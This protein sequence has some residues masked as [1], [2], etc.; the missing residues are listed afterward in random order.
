MTAKRLVRVGLWLAAAA[1]AAAPAAPARAAERP[2]GSTVNGL[3]L[4]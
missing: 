4:W 1:C 3:G 2:G